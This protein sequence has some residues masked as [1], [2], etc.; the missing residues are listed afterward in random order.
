MHREVPRSHV[1]VA[2]CELDFFID[3]VTGVHSDQLTAVRA[4]HGIW[5]PQTPES[6]S[7]EIFG[8]L[9]RRVSWIRTLL[10]VWECSAKL[11]ENLLEAPFQPLGWKGI[12]LQGADLCPAMLPY[13]YIPIIMCTPVSSMHVRSCLYCRSHL[14]SFVACVHVPLCM[15]V[16]IYMHTYTMHLYIY[17]CIP[18]YV[19]MYVCAY[20]YI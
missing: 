20:I 6:W 10:S 2:N 17:V 19:C 14:Y 3:R 16:Y 4:V 11:S 5:T 8:C 9:R 18:M 15:C 1:S 13:I 12:H 7:L